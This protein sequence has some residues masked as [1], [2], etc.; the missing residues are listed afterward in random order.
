MD[1]VSD[2]YF[3]MGNIFNGRIYSK[4]YIPYHI[5]NCDDLKLGSDIGLVQYNDAVLP[6]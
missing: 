5:T 4:E 1:S 6:M 2:G 3:H